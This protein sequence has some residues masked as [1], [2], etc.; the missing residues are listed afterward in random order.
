[1]VVIASVVTGGQTGTLVSKNFELCLSSFPASS[2]TRAVLT[3]ALPETDARSMRE[4]GEG[5][6]VG[7]GLIGHAAWSGGTAGS[8][9]SQGILHLSFPFFSFLS[10]S[11]ERVRASATGRTHDYSTCHP[12]VRLFEAAMGRQERE[13]L[14]LLLV[15]FLATR[16]VCRGP[17]ELPETTIYQN[18]CSP[19]EWRID[20][21]CRRGF[22]GI[23][24]IV[25]LVVRPA[26]LCM[27]MTHMHAS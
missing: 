4:V 2:S 18:D 11:G 25:R 17:S 3:M 23:V 26:F 10:R 5:G 20:N 1:L 6:G 15:G 27:Y 9:R 21:P 14:S 13:Q 22:L 19:E 7:E 24:S 16:V 12:W 8:A